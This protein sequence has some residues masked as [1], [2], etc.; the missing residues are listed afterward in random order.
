MLRQ[1]DPKT[2]MIITADEWVYTPY[3]QPLNI[4]MNEQPR[5]VGSSLSGR[6]TSFNQAGLNHVVVALTVER[7]DHIYER[8]IPIYEK[9]NSDEAPTLFRPDVTSLQFQCQHVVVELLAVRKYIERR[10]E[11]YHDS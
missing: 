11:A 8:H 4:F 7:K 1:N 2:A 10:D 3:S 5:S 6:R 9:Q